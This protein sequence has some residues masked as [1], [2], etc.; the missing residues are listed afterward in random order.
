MKKLIVNT[1]TIELSEEDYDNV[2]SVIEGK[3]I[4][5]DVLPADIKDLIGLCYFYGS[6]V[7]QDYEKAI[8]WYMLAAEEGDAAAERNLGNCYNYAYGVRKDHKRAAYWYERAANH[9]H[10]TAQA[11]LAEM[12]FEGIG[13]QRDEEK[14]WY[15]MEKA[16]ITA[17]ETKNHIVLNSF[18]DDHYIGRRFERNLGVAELFYRKAAEYGNL[19]AKL[20]VARMIWRGQADGTE[21]EIEELIL[22]V[23]DEAKPNDRVK[24]YGEMLLKDFH[25]QRKM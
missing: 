4:S 25:S 22:S 15:W 13:V 17:F 24:H 20:H 12:Y 7:E 19:L 18:G 3:E 1:E 11:L 8:H 10:A 23:I 2:F 5:Y 9:G 6:N 16:M 21:E 14:G